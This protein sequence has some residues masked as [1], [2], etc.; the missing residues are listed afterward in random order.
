VNDDVRLPEHGSLMTKNIAEHVRRLLAVFS[1]N[2][3]REKLLATL[4][5]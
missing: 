2:I 4:N 5:I 3:T 1:L